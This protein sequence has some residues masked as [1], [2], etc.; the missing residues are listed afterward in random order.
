MKRKYQVGGI[1]YQLLQSQPQTETNDIID[2][3]TVKS[4]AHSPVMIDDRISVGYT[5]QFTIN[6]NEQ[7]PEIINEDSESISD[8]PITTIL[9]G[10]PEVTTQTQTS[11]P[12]V[13]TK[14]TLRGKSDFKNLEKIYEKALKKRGIDTRYAK[15]LAAQD[16][17]ESGWGKSQGAKVHNYGNL[18]TDKSWKGNYIIGDDSDGK[19]N[20]I[21][22]KF[23]SYN[24]VEEYVE[25]KINF[26]HYKRYAGAFTGNPD[27]FIEKIWKA[28]YATAPKYVS[29]VKSVYNNWG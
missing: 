12:S 27:D 4:D 5:P 24:S 21:K 16:A 29:A 26:L 1:I 28:G 8:V 13:A 14:N 15:W 2:L 3:S 25:D 11:T 7:E 6:Q 23:R 20:P 17:L 18:T 19:G 22:Q 10:I 9:T